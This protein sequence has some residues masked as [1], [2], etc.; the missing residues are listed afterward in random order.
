MKIAIVGSRS[1]KTLDIKEHLP[2]KIDCIISGGAAGVDTIARNFAIKNNI[3]LIEYL[4]DYK[5]HGRGAPHIRNREIVK[6][7]DLLLAFWDGKSKGTVSSLNAAKKL[8][9]KIT[10]IKVPG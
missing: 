4:P 3:E 2:A 7:C 1:I 10:V 5:K 6:N 8:G 9:K